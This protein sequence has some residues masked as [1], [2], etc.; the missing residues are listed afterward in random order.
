ME[1]KLPEFKK[2]FPEVNKIDWF[3]LSQRGPFLSDLMHKITGKIISLKH[4]GHSYQIQ[5]LC[6]PF[7]S[8]MVFKIKM[9]GKQD[10]ILKMSAYQL[11]DIDSDYKRK[12][13]E[14]QAIR[15][16]SPFSN[17]LM[18]FYLKL[19]KCPHA[20]SILYYTDQYEAVLYK[21]EKGRF[22]DKKERL[23]FLDVNRKKLKDANRLGIYVNDIS[24]GNFVEGKNGVYKI[25]DI[26]HASFANPLTQGVPGLTFTFGNLCGQD[27]L[28][29]FG[30]MSLED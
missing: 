14:N 23:N 15:A 3:D 11:G 8:K 17:A 7:S 5:F 13:S 2:V 20:P 30:V 28:T 10:F 27:Y 12:E 19:N 9:D 22:L 26:G 25:I 6:N 21:L 4:L 16:D 24:V 18:E 1:N 29:H